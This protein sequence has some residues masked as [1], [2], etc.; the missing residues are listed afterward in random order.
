MRR[1]GVEVLEFH[2]VRPWDVLTSWRPVQRNHRKL[3]LID[4]HI[5]GLGGLNLAREYAGPWLTGSAASPGSPRPWRDNAVGIVGPGAGLFLRAFAR[6]WNYVIR[7]GPMRR[8]EFQ[9]ELLDGD[10]GVLASVPTM[11]SPLVRRLNELMSRARESI[12]LTMAYF[13]PPEA[14]VDDLCR[15][16]RRGVRVRLML[17]SS[18]D[19]RLLLVAARSFYAKLLAAGVEIYERHGAVLHAKT[20]LVDR[21]TTVIGSS[22][23]DYRS[24]EKNFEISAVIRSRRFGEQIHDLFEHDVRFARRITREEWRR[25]PM[26][27]RLGQWAVSRARYLL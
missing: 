8:A 22:N 26:L 15:A 12:E 25:R 2:P 24:I 23:L 16:A 20:L 14:L 1:A 7:G 18:L 6:T 21:L 11:A 17:P 27:D 19:V 10:L 9:V 5:A 4:N 3:L 13:A